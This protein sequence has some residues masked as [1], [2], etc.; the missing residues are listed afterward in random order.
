LFWKAQPGRLRSH[1]QTFE[2]CWVWFYKDVAPTA[3]LQFFSEMKNRKVTTKQLLEQIE[4]LRNELFV[5]DV[6]FQLLLD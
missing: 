1:F 2:I 3:R 6:Q 5:T 4:K